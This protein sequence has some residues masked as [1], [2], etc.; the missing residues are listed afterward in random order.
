MLSKIFSVSIRF[1]PTPVICFIYLIY[2]A[3]STYVQLHTILIISPSPFFIFWNINHAQAFGGYQ[4][5]LHPG[6]RVVHE[7]QWHCST[8]ECCTQFAVLMMAI[9]DIELIFG[10][11]ELIYRTPPPPPNGVSVICQRL[12]IKMQFGRRWRKIHM[13]ISLFVGNG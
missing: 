7:L 1:N 13:G 3:L 8:V 11:F 6:Y 5:L 10:T 9:N 2:P 4:R 12:F